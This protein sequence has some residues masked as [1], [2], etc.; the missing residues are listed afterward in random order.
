MLPLRDVAQRLDETWP[1]RMIAPSDEEGNRRDQFAEQ[2]P[3]ELHRIIR[4]RLPY[5]V[6]GLFGKRDETR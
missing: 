2:I 4:S 1:R 6:C 5:P 3:V